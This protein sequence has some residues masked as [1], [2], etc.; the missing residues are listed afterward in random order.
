MEWSDIWQ[1]P[2]AEPV[3]SV[4]VDAAPLPG[5]LR[6]FQMTTT[7]ELLDP[8]TGE[9]ALQWQSDQELVVRAQVKLL[10]NYEKFFDFTECAANQW[11]QLG[12]DYTSVIYGGT[13]VVTGNV[14]DFTSK[15]Q[16][17]PPASTIVGELTAH[18]LA[19]SV[20]QLWS[21]VWIRCLLP[22]RPRHSERGAGGFRHQ[23]CHSGSPDLHTN[24]T[25]LFQ[26]LAL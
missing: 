19:Q 2:W 20:D 12:K 14:T 21:Q 9:R 17:R 5:P 25:V 22:G 7:Y 11:L 3:R 16:V 24:H 10:N 18:R 8:K 4:F 26:L 1:R 6:D 23:E 15:T 13:K